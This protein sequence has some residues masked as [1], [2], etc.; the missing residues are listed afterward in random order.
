LN[1]LAVTLAALVAAPDNQ[2]ITHASPDR[3]GQAQVLPFLAEDMMNAK[4]FRPHAHLLLI[5]AVLASFGLSLWS[6]GV[7]RASTNITVNSFADAVN[8]SDHACT[9]REAVIAANKDQASGSKSGECPAGSGTDTIVLPSGTYTLTRTDNG[10][11]DST[12]RAT[13]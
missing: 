3:L 9:L 8:S 5:V 11:E 4:T 10:N 6:T 13:W 7:S 12:S 2:N 1:L